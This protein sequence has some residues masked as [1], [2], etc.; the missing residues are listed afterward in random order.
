[1]TEQLEMSSPEDGAAVIGGE[2]DAPALSV[3]QLCGIVASYC[4]TAAVI[5]CLAKLIG[6]EQLLPWREFAGCLLLTTACG[7]TGLIMVCQSCRQRGDRGSLTL[8]SVVVRSVPVW[9]LVGGMNAI[10]ADS[11]SLE[12]F[13]TIGLCYLLTLFLETLFSVR[14]ISLSDKKLKHCSGRVE[15]NAAIAEPSSRNVN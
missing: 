8:L 12:F 15:N 13:R 3:L 11:I 5:A 1:M 2:A 14:S 4:V 6:G 10:H 9:L 7:A